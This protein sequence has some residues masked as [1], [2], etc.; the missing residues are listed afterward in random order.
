MDRDSGGGKAKRRLIKPLPA[1]NG[2]VAST[3]SS[4]GKDSDSL[5]QKAWMEWIAEREESRR[6]RFCVITAKRRCEG[7]TSFGLIVRWNVRKTTEV[8]NTESTI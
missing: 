5:A 3:T 6:Y 8:P 2:T 1:H 7:T 4:G